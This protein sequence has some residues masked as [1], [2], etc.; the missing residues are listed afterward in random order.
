MNSPIIWY[1]GKGVLKSKRTCLWLKNLPLLIPTEIVKPTIYGY[2]KKGRHKGE[3][4][5]WHEY[6]LPMKDRG[7]IRSKSFEGISKVI[8]DQWGG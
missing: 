4:I 5:Y 2:H 3:P 7:K 6:C 8:A 1:G